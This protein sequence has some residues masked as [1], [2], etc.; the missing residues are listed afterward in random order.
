MS[1]SYTP[2]PFSHSFALLLLDLCI[3]ADTCFTSDARRQGRPVRWVLKN[4]GGH[5]IT[6]LYPYPVCYGEKSITCFA[7]ARD[8]LM[9]VKINA[10][11]RH[12]PSK[13]RLLRNSV[14]MVTNLRILD[15]S[16]T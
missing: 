2:L 9:V 10:A 12:V 4:R 15:Q 7:G 13:D 6:V 3:L 14:P 1:R 8:C 16:F 5:C 11:S